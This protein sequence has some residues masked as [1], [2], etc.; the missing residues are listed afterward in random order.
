MATNKKPRKKLHTHQKITDIPTSWFNT[1]F[2]PLIN[3]LDNL[4]VEYFYR[5]A[6]KTSSASGIFTTTN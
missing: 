6:V 5:N 1:M 2:P 3:F 4:K